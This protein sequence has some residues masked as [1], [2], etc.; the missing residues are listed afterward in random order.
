MLQ[1][2]IVSRYS[3]NIMLS[4]VKI[5]I[6]LENLLTETYMDKI[7]CCVLLYYHC[8]RVKT[9]FAVKINNKKMPLLDNFTE[10][11]SPTFFG[12]AMLVSVVGFS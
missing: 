2:V 6:F 12:T 7:V 8:K 10:G 9:P 3:Y 4:T 1:Q 11:K 5:F